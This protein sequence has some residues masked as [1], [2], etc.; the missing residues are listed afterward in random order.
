[1]TNQQ[2]APQIVVCPDADEASRSVA[3]IIAEAVRSN[4][5]IVL[6][7]ATGGTPLGVY[8]EL[9]RMHHSEGLDFA[10]VR[11][12]NL[13]EYRGL[14]PD[15][16]QSYRRFMQQ[17]LFEQINI[18]PANTHVPDGLAA[19]LSA[20]AEEYERRIE[21]AGGID[22]QLLGIGSNGHIAFNEPGSLA[23]SRTREIEL[24]AETVA[25]NARFFDS[26]DQV[27]RYAITMGIGTILQARRIVLMAIGQAKASAVQA[28]IEGD[29]DPANPASLLQRHDDVTYVLD[30]AAAEQLAR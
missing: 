15:H 27:P 12:F 26:K 28:A 17:N 9:A 8:R 30:V 13:D 5:R 18:D 16:P 29:A 4:P 21:A 11:S 2:A 7:L 22:L 14:A 20:H 6:G 3:Q 24:T 10:E 19:D 1:M 25:A 23:D